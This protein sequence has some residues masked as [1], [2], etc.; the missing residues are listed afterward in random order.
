MSVIVFRGVIAS[1]IGKHSQLVIPGRSEL[2]SAPDDWPEQLCPGSLNVKLHDDGLPAEFSER[3]SGELVRK[4]DSGNFRPEFVIPQSAMQ[5]N[6]LKPKTDN[7]NRGVGQVWRTTL[8]HSDSGRSAQCWV[9]RRIGSALK[10]QLEIV[11]HEKI[12]VEYHLTDG[13]EV[14]AHLNGTWIA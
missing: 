3:C 1:G 2:D 6:K 11:S 8:I 9:L 5:N 4:L 12:R 13:D 14:E 7:P 10:R